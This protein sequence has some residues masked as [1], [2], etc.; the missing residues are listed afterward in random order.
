M[1]RLEAGFTLIELMIVVAIIGVLAAI[2]IPSYQDYT[3]RAQV[4]EALNL[5]A[6][7]KVAVSEYYADH[8]VFPA[9]SDVAQTASG[10]YVVSSIAFN[11]VTGGTLA[12]TAT[13]GTSGVAAAI[14][15]STFSIAT[16]DGALTWGVRV[17]SNGI[18]HQSGRSQ[19][20]ARRLQVR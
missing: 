18:Q 4:T 16:E 10:K 12:I 13:F 8:G 20:R 11:N 14:A 17:G 15:G 7:Y 1:K 3:A 9:Y 6:Q 5:T 19:I 2:A